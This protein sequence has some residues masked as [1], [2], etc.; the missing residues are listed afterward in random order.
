M[1]LPPAFSYEQS[2]GPTGTVRIALTG[3]LDV[4][5]GASLTRLLNRLLGSDVLLDLADLEFLDSHGAAA[6]VV[7]NGRARQHGGNL[8]LTPPHGQVHRTLS[9]LGLLRLFEFAD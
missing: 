1:S 3:E 6:L 2:T 5:S 4:A 8:R 7:A 9:I